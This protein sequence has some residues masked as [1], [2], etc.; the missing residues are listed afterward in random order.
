MYKALALHNFGQATAFFVTQCKP[1][2]SVEPERGVLKPHATME[3]KVICTPNCLRG[4]LEDDIFFVC[5]DIRLKVKVSCEVVEANIFMHDSK[6]SFG[7][8]FMN[9]QKQEIVKITNKSPYT[10]N[11][12]W[13][14]YKSNAIDALEKNR[15]SGAMEGMTN[16]MRTR[17]TKLEFMNIID[18]EGH[19]TVIEDQC[20]KAKQELDEKWRFLYK[21]EV[22]TI[23]P[24]EG[25][26]HPNQTLEFMVVFNPK[27][28]D[29]Y[30]SWAYL[31]I[32]G[33]PERLPLALSGVGKG[34]VVVFNA[35]TLNISNVYMNARH[36]YQIV[37]KNDSHIPATVVF[38]GGK[39]EFGGD[40]EC[41]PTT[42]YLSHFDKCKSFVIKFSSSVQGQFVEKVQFT[43]EESTEIIH[44]LLIGNVVCPLLKLSTN[45]VD[46]GDIPF[47][48]C[49]FQEFQLVNEAQ[50]PINYSI[51]VEDMSNTNVEWSLGEHVV[52]PY[53]NIP[54]LVETMSS[55]G[56]CTNRY[57][58]SKDHLEQSH[59]ISF[60]L[61]SLSDVDANIW[62]TMWGSQK[63]R[64]SIPIHIRP[65][66]PELECDP[67]EVFMNFCFLDFEYKR[68]IKLKNTTD[69]SGRLTYAPIKEPENMSCN[70]NIT[71]CPITPFGEIVIE[72]TV[73][74]SELGPHEYDLRFEVRGVP[75]KDYCKVTCNG[76]GPV[77]IHSPDILNFGEVQLLETT[78]CDLTITNESPITA[79]L[80]I[81]TKPNEPFFVKIP[82]VVIA[83]EESAVIPV[84]CYLKDTGKYDS[85]VRYAIKNGE[86]I[87]VKISAIG[88]GCSILC[89]P[90]I[91]E[92]YN[93]RF[94]LTHQ[95]FRLYVKFTNLGKKFTKI[96]WTRKK[97]VKSLKDTEEIKSVFSMTPNQF[98]LATDQFQMVEIS[99]A[100]TKVTTAEEDFY[101]FATYDK[102]SKPIL[103]MSFVI[104]ASFIEPEVEFSKT[105][106]EFMVSINETGNLSLTTPVS[107]KQDVSR[108]SSS[109]PTM[110]YLEDNRSLFRGFSDAFSVPMEDELN[111]LSSSESEEEDDTYPKYSIL[112]GSVDIKNTT[113]IPLKMI[114]RTSPAFY[115][116]KEG[117]LVQYMNLEIHE[118]KMY[119]ARV[120]FVPEIYEKRYRRDEGTLTLQFE[121]HPKSVR[122]PLYNQLLYP[123]VVFTPNEADFKC[124]PPYSIYS[125]TIIMKNI[126]CMP[127]RFSWTLREEFFHIERLT[128]DAMADSKR[129]LEFDPLASDLCQKH[130]VRPYKPHDHLSTKENAHLEMALAKAESIKGFQM[131]VEQESNRYVY[132]L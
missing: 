82:E 15:L 109:K 107:R 45:V 96:L 88:A 14:L 71:E 121:A 20:K 54:I 127:V 72:L 2:F 93:A 104:K 46:F 91:K 7:E 12:Y 112:H 67:P 80:K 98:E 57:S 49:A 28:N 129:T 114:L 63:Y 119:T 94:L 52:Q 115:I 33:K 74:T 87:E 17:H 78:S 79:Q 125:M 55:T 60:V 31:D 100:S 76:Q 44:F 8:V 83:S 58:T 38:R 124:V 48:E 69:Y 47:G 131:L 1:P 39:T 59:K 111:K 84:Y 95:I 99:G 108:R 29:Y 126:T 105:Q 4:Y 40:I 130:E 103:L 13:S 51:S 123:T 32:G 41:V 97:A 68:K 9:L 11:F 118:G 25:V 65:R 23:I 66:V 53:S 21:N 89:E 10:V 128:V 42:R 106:L 56:E 90:S 61:D 101:C 24:N 22:F 75:P 16:L 19:N 102:S 122:L 73:K 18:A 30:S 86:T 64:Q 50:V 117:E 26:L 120:E 92:G 36:E 27:I 70:L 37:V 62:L 34:P 116:Y 113:P 3:I 77:V 35:N 110:D 81:F 5:D 85:Y 132:Y 43:I 6:I